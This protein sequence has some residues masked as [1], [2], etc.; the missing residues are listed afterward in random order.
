[1]PSRHYVLV[2]GLAIALC[3][4]LHVAGRQQPTPGLLTLDALVDI[5]YP[6]LPAWSP[7]GSR[8]AFV[9]DRGGVQNVWVAAIASAGARPQPVTSF[10]A[11]TIENLYWSGDGRAVFFGRGGHLW[12]ANANALDPGFRPGAAP[13]W[14]ATVLESQ[15]VPS[16]DGTRIAFVRGGPPDR[17]DWQRTEGD[18]WVRML[19]DGKETRLTD[20]RGVVSAPAWS[21]DGRYLAFTIGPAI[22]RSEAPSYSGAKIQYTRVDHPPSAAAYVS[23]NGGPVTRFPESP[24]WDPTPA[25]VDASHLVMQHVG[26]DN[27]TREIVVADVPSAATH[28]VFREVDRKFWS[29]PFVASEVVPSPNGRWIAF[30]SDHDGWDHL[31]VVAAGGGEAKQITRGRFE[32]RHLSWSPDSRAIAFDRSL[33]DRPGVRHLA[34]AALNEQGS[35]AVVTKTAGRGTN[36]AAQWSP[37]GRRLLYQHTDPQTSPELFV[38][39]AS[40]EPS[41]APVRLTD[42]MPRGVDG[43][44]LVDPQLV[45]YRASDGQAV[46]AY[47][48]VPPDLDRRTRHP[49]IVWIHGDGINQNYD[50]WHVERNYAVYYAFH[51]YLLQHG[52]VVLAPD[53][54]G[55]IGYGRDWRQGVYMDVGGKDAGDAAAAAGYLKTLPYV[56]G[57]RIGV[58]GLSYGGFFT[59]IAL[60][61][62]PASFRCGVDVAGVVDYR[63]WYEDP[64]GAW[65][66]AR[67]GTPETRPDVYD[68]AAVINRVSRIERPLLVL[69]GAADVN[70]PYI[71]SVRLIDE[72]LK[73]RKDVAFMMYPGE[74][75]YFQRAHV[76]RDAWTRVAAFFGKHLQPPE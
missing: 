62:Y 64:G 39:D 49:A 43:R 1:M 34:L 58:W 61:D 13:L 71:E 32:V 16:P 4:A 3:T 29:L 68:K 27:R 66:T 54:R 30:V 38:V 44:R 56:D 51:Q 36:I 31:H 55:S 50:G 48:F 47:L 74:F 52:Y 45:S 28:V 35:G 53:Y 25:W 10:E 18:L 70:V 40:S 37:D 72:M 75:H 76:L 59:L 41:A 6:A 60:T 73:Q 46:P 23:A 65:V 22:A 33:E 57:D 5:R 26:D 20:G 7:D 14:T 67:M 8:V 9:W 15:F 2:L 17:S 24:G 42:S 69:H 21:P 19:A 63:M 12:R 11:G